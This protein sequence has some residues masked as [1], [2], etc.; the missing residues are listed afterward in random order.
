MDRVY[1]ITA[2]KTWACCK[3]LCMLSGHHTFLMSLLHSG[4]RDATTV[5]TPLVLCTVMS[6]CTKPDVK[7]IDWSMAKL[8]RNTF[9]S[10]V[11]LGHVSEK[12]SC[13]PWD[14]NLYFLWQMIGETGQ[15]TRNCF[16]CSSYYI[17]FLN[18]AGEA[19][20]HCALASCSEHK[21]QK[22]WGEHTR[23]H[24]IKLT[25][26]IF[27]YWFECLTKIIVLSRTKSWQIQPHFRLEY[28]QHF[29]LTVPE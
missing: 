2:W 25:L 18:A 3:N 20:K 1:C 14:N 23:R 29:T 7:Q 24:K 13:P 5:I 15:L 17:T 6:T 12:Q 22:Y 9:N 8:S 21:L 26:G 16:L 28:H 27:L 11:V 10:A 19:L 4:R